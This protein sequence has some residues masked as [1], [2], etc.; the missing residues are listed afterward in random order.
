MGNDLISYR[1]TIGLFGRCLIRK[2][3]LVCAVLTLTTFIN[4]SKI[5]FVLV[6]LLLCCGDIE[7]NPGPPSPCKLS[8]VNYNVCGLKNKLDLIIANLSEY[9]I[10]AL[11]ESHLT[12]V[13]DN[14]SIAIPG[15]HE[16]YRCDRDIGWGGVCLYVADHI[17]TTRRLDL[18]HNELEMVCLEIHDYPKTILMTIYR[19]PNTTVD[20]WQLITDVIEQ[21]MDTLPDSNL[22]ITGDLNNDLLQNSQCHL[23]DII[24]SFGFIQVIKEPTRPVSNTLLDPIICNKSE[25]IIDSGVLQPICS[26]HIPVYAT[27]RSR[28]PKHKN[29]RRNIWDYEKAD[30]DKFENILRGF[31]WPPVNSSTHGINNYCSM[32][33]QNIMNAACESIPNKVVTIRPSDKP[34]MKNKI[35]HEMRIR[36]KLY[37]KR[38]LSEEDLLAYNKQR[39]Y[40]N[41][42]ILNAKNEYSLEIAAKIKDGP[43]N[44][45]FWWKLSKS[46]LKGTNSEFNEIPPLKKHD[47][48]FAYEI[49]DKANLLNEYFANISK[50]DDSNSNL[51]NIPDYTMSSLQN[52]CITEEETLKI[53]ASLNI[54]KA[55]G[56]D[57]VSPR[58]LHA[59]RK[60]LSPILTKFFN[61]SLSSG[62]YPDLWKRAHIT[63]I[64]KKDDPSLTSNY[65]PVSLLSCTSKVFEKIV[66]NKLMAYLGDLITDKQSGFLPFHSTVTQ[67]LEIYDEIVQA[68]NCQKEIQFLFFDISKAFDRVW[69]R[70]LLFKLEKFGIKNTMLQW[71]KSYLTNR[72]QCVILKGTKS[73]YLSID[74]G[75]PQG[76]VL[77]PT[78]FLL[79]INDLPSGI[80]NNIRLFA[81]DT[82]LYVASEEMH[83]KT[84]SINRDMDLI[85]NW[86]SQW[87]VN[88]NASKT[89]NL[90]V[91]RRREPTKLNIT[92]SGKIIT[93]SEEHKHLGILINSKGTWR[94]HVEVLITS[95][96]KKLSIFRGLKYKLDRKSLEIM[97]KTVIRPCFEYG[98]VIW[99]N[100]DTDLVIKLEHIQKDCLRVITGLTRSVSTDKLYLEAGFHTLAER[101]HIHKLIMFHKIVKNSAPRALS[102]KL[103]P[104]TAIRNPYNVRNNDMFTLYHSNINLYRNSFFPSTLRAWNNLPPLIRNCQTLEM[105]KRELFNLYKVLPP[106][107]WFYHGPR[108]TN[109][110]LCRIRNDCSSLNSHLYNNH[111]RD[112]PQCACGFEVESPEHYFLHC[113][114]FTASRLQMISHLLFYT[115]LENIDITFLLFGNPNLTVNDNISSTEI[116]QIF[117]ND[118]GRFN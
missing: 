17:A 114:L 100:I 75:V 87:L 35:K 106:L 56:P 24:N 116:V 104:T 63:P 74:A 95:A 102:N 54:S 103:P 36:D 108:K 86:A 41:K 14:S 33:T 72:K 32:I 59:G 45:K 79:Y 90:L 31:D 71:F 84:Q 94:N 18:E 80:I 99:D 66:T 9:D 92:F 7:I 29:F 67:L 73:E 77:G 34:W 101:R 107:P 8:L 5:L 91:S 10:I 21:V 40:V 117:I 64:H 69:H 30:W 2:T 11:T 1:V 50:V 44:S 76:S 37:K 60:I 13:I 78:L 82:C 83:N 85:R 109:V 62:I 93:P 89:V 28:I 39:N 57:D 61:A 23:Q 49:L 42:L 43:R 51:P 12:K 81:D 118:T 22:I 113:T 48:T 105:F 47:S 97:Y 52:L 20:K 115:S 65:R 46:L 96:H 19:P 70:G 26:D 25:L 68:L 38:K 6:L 4:L 3:V 111:I 53:L 88:F 112:N 15:Y 27:L 58:V 55:V 98:D 110:T 16:P